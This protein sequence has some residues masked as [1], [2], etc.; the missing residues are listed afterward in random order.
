[1]AEECNR[2]ENLLAAVGKFL[3][4]GCIYIYATLGKIM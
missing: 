4:I 3:N 1:L 2:I